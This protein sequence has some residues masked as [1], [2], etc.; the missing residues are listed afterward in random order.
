MQAK[1]ED[2][3]NWGKFGALWARILSDYTRLKLTH[4]T[5]ALPALSGLAQR[6]SHFKPGAY[7]AGLWEKDIACSLDWQISRGENREALPEPTFSWTASSY[8][9]SFGIIY[10]KEVEATL[11]HYVS[12][13]CTYTTGNVYGHV[14]AA[15]LCL[16]GQAVSGLDLFNATPQCFDNPVSKYDNYVHL[17]NGQMLGAN[18]LGAD[19]NLL[20]KSAPT[21]PDRSSVICFALYSYTKY[22]S[23]RICATL[24]VLQL[25]GD[26]VGQYVRIGLAR[27][28]KKVW[29]DE[30]ASP[31]TVTIT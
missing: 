1:E 2:S 27:D 21:S 4:A 13:D 24:L 22:S 10:A 7:I 18:H 17:D 15:S 20:D 14:S 16:R 11:C 19:G 25:K 8:P 30:H 26:A 9:V 5:D 31:I 28:I 12:H 6:M 29:F 23:K 3:T